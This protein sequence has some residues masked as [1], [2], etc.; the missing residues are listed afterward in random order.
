MAAVHFITN[1]ANLTGLMVSFV[2]FVCLLTTLRLVHI[3]ILELLVRFNE[4]C[5]GFRALKIWVNVT[6][7]I[8]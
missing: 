5:Y 4:F 2:I 8:I 3:K 7:A 6:A 1:L